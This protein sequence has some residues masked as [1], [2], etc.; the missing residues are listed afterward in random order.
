[1]SDKR[2]PYETGNSNPAWTS[3][4]VHLN[5][6]QPLPPALIR[7]AYREHIAQLESEQ[8]ALWADCMELRQ[9]WVESAELIMPS[10]GEGLTQHLDRV[11]RD[12]ALSAPKPPLPRVSFFARIVDSI[13]R[14]FR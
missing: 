9:A 5:N 4:V 13:R 12:H 1:M 11:V 6:V 2:P 7:A 14:F 8:Q 3:L 10:L